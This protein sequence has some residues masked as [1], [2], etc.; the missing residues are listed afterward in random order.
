[1]VKS[2]LAAGLS[3]WIARAVTGLPDPVLAPLTALVVVQVSVRAS[4][5]TAIH[6]SIA[7][8]LGVLVAFAIGDA[9]GLNGLTVAL[10]VAGTLGIAQLVLRLPPSAARQVPISVLVVLTTVSSRQSYGWRRTLDTV[11]GAAVGVGISLLLPASRVVDA[12]QTLDRLAGSLGVELETMGA[13]LQQPWSTA[14]TEDWRRRAHTVRDRLVS[15]AAEAVGDGREVARW[16][17]RDRRHI[18]V[19][20]RYEEVMQRLERTA[21]GTSVISRG[22]DDHARLTGTTHRAMPAMG[23]LLIALASAVRAVVRDV[24]RDSDDADVARSLAEVRARRERCIQG[25]SRR[26]RLALEDE[27]GPDGDHLEGEWLGYAALLVQVDRI[28]AD[29]SAPLPA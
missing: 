28:V 4:V 14:E 17:V 2:G 27:E 22:L 10:L 5:R 29:L 20:G 23:E 11:L 13:G 25:A 16:N 12:R 26:A 18:Q 15:E 3:W 19:L 24:L 9:L 6:R 1:V 7:V 8:V 21:I